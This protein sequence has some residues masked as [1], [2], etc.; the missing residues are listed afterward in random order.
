MAHQSV[1]EGPSLSSI[2]WM[3]LGLEPIGVIPKLKSTEALVFTSTRLRVLRSEEDQTWCTEACMCDVQL[4]TYMHDKK[5]HT[6]THK[7]T[8]TLGYLCLVAIAYLSSCTDGSSF[9][10]WISLQPCTMHSTLVCHMD[11][12][13]HT[14]THTHAHTRTHTPHTHHTQHTHTHT[15]T[16]THLSTESILHSVDLL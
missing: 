15:H 10:Q 1:G 14:H 7:H 5:T 11:N 2:R 4:R 3:V 8:H 6:H 9:K 13:H 16:H 12:T